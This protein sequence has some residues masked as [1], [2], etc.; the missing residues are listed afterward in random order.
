MKLRGWI[1]VGGPSVGQSLPP[2]A[3]CGDYR[4]EPPSAG[5]FKV[6]QWIYWLASPV[7]SLVTLVCVELPLH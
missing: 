5:A 3:Y 6:G 1:I 7:S 2:D 4:G